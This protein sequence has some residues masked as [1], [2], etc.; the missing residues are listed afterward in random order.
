MGRECTSPLIKY[1]GHAEEYVT[2]CNILAEGHRLNKPETPPLA[3][4]MRPETLPA[5]IGFD[6]LDLW[7]CK[8]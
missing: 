2:Y 3:S 8:T 4:G 6:G 5:E 1:Y 7:C